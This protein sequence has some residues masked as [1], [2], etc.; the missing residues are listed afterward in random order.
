LKLQVSEDIRRVEIEQARVAA[1]QAALLALKRR[2]EAVVSDIGVALELESAG[3]AVKVEELRAWRAAVRALQSVPDRER[4]LNRQLEQAH[5]SAEREGALSDLPLGPDQSQVRVRPIRHRQ[6]GV[7][8]EE[9][10]SEDVSES[11]GSLAE[12]E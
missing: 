5:T 6:V 11:S 7:T 9:A 12:M 4:E 10:G 8:A 1:E 2:G 3:L